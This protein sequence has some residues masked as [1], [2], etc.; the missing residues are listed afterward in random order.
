MTGNKTV[1]ERQIVG[2]YKELEKDAWIIA[3][4]K[5]NVQKKK[6]AGATIGGDEILFR[7]LK[8]REFHMDKIREYKNEGAIGEGN[9]GYIVYRDIPKYEKSRDHKNILLKVI[10]EENKA[11]KIIFK[12]MLVKSGKKEPAA[13]EIMA[14]GRLFA[15]EQRA[16][17]KKNDWIQ[18]K[19]GR[20]VKQK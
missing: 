1:I 9:T 7:A 14:F 3:S 11:R 15:N 6:G 19:N 2:D 5:T 17:A 12:R 8:V 10:N 18:E 13:D 4:M 16:F 20:W